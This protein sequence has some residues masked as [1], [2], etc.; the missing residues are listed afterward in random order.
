MCKEEN[1]CAAASTCC[2]RQTRETSRDRVADLFGIPDIVGLD[3][4]DGGK[5]DRANTANANGGKSPPFCGSQRKGYFIDQ[6]GTQPCRTGLLYF[7]LAL[8]LGYCHDL[9]LRLHGVHAR[10]LSYVI[11]F[12]VIDQA[13]T[14]PC[15]TGLLSFRLGLTRTHCYVSCLILGFMLGYCRI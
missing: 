8:T 12:R 4:A 7:R 9:Y 5:G 2:Q 1:R 3:A 11:C 6:A 14:H 10:V 13:G 15:G